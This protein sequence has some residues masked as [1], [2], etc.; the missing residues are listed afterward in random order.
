MLRRFSDGISDMF[1]QSDLLLLLFCIIASGFGMLMIASATNYL[2]TWRY[3][4]IQGVA[5]VLGIILYFL[6]SSLD[7]AEITKKGWKWMLLFNVVFILLLLTPFGVADDTGNRAWR[8]PRRCRWRH[9][10]DRGGC[11][12]RP[13]PCG[14]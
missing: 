7:L 12:R 11:A 5:T 9:R 14:R 1:R 10:G 8:R 3:V 2:D 6:I 13:S 4:L